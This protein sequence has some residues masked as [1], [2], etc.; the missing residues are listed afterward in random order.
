MFLAEI[1]IPTKSRY[2]PSG[3]NASVISDESSVASPAA[4]LLQINSHT[5]GRL[6]WQYLLELTILEKGLTRFSFQN[7]G[8]MCVWFIAC[9]S[10]FL[11]HPESS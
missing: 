8:E 1:K 11:V 9:Q 10:Y 7:F 4:T 2:V 6:H 3:K 5:P